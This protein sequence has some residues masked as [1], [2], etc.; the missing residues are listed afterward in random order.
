M[1]RHLTASCNAH[2]D[3]ERANLQAGGPVMRYLTETV[4]LLSPLIAYAVRSELGIL[5]LFIPGVRPDVQDELAVDLIAE[6][7]RTGKDEAWRAGAA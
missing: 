1:C 5:V 3:T 6:L 2:A 7:E 4:T